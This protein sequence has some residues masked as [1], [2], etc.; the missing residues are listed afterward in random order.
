[1]KVKQKL[2][3]SA[4]LTSVV[5][6]LLSL[7]CWSA[8]VENPPEQPAQSASAIEFNSGFIHGSGIDVS[9]YSKGNPIA[10]GVYSVLISI[11]G[12]KRGRYDVTFNDAGTSENA[13]AMFTLEELQ[14][15]GIKLEEETI[16]QLGLNETNKEKSYTIQ[17]LIKNSKVYYNQGDFELGITVPQANLIQFPRGYTD[18]S[19]WDAGETAG[20]I[21]IMQISMVF[22]MV[23]LKRKVVTGN[24]IPVI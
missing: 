5:F 11:N 13:P 22:L 18:P 21:D 1:M 19:R 17:E 16:K 7:K 10:P 12:E 15:I 9:R 20:Y 14:R 23:M 4:T 24:P 2:S 8:Q 3:S 6:S